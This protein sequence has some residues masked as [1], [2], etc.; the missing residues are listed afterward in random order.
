VIVD[1]IY[2]L[3]QAGLKVGPNEGLAVA[4]A[5]GEN[6]HETTLDGFYNVTRALFVHREQD[7]DPFD[8]AFGHHFKGLEM[9]AVELAEELLEW[10]KDPKLGRELTDEE[11]AMLESLDLEEIKRRGEERLRE[12]KKRHDGGN[13]W[14]GTGGTSPFGNAGKHPGGMR[15]GGEQPGTGAGAMAVAAARKARGL[16][17]DVTLDT[18]QIELALRRLRAFARDG[19]AEELDIEGTIDATAKNAGELEVVTRPPRRSNVRVLL[20]LDI[21]GSMDPHAEVCSRL[22]SAAKRATHFRELKTYYFHNCVYGKLYKTPRLEAG[23]T[24]ADVLSVCDPAW[25]LVVVG[26]ASMHP[27]ELTATSGSWTWGDQTGVPGVMWLQ[28]LRNHFRKSAWVNPEPE[29]QWSRGTMGAIKR[30]FPMFQLTLDGLVLAMHHLTR[31]GSG[32]RR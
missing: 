14:I 30:V 10:L 11:R 25:K 8:V 12:Q 23:D 1:F 17:G 28:M 26:D 18:R 24:V 5:L 16:R 9:K 22:F 2:T 6:L 4:R 15:V 32:G 29:N 21:G 20:L 3:R 31:G 19:I 13:K 27:T 7:L